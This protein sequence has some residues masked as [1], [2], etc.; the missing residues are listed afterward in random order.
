[1]SR[2]ERSNDK[3]QRDRAPDVFEA[4]AENAEV[5]SWKCE[6]CDLMIENFQQ[7]YCRACSQYWTDV[8]MGVF[9]DPE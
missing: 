3:F 4:R 9:D 2:I 6:T 8:Q 1:M 7:Q 5:K